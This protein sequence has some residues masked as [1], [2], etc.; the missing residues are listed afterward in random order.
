ME[1]GS[2]QTNSKPIFYS[3]YWY[4]ETY[5][6]TP[7]IA[8][9]HQNKLNREKC[10][11]IRQFNSTSANTILFYIIYDITIT[12]YQLFIG[13]LIYYTWI[14]VLCVTCLNIP[15]RKTTYLIHFKVNLIHLNLFC[16]SSSYLLH[17]INFLLPKYQIF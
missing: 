14:S 16:F 7:Y 2:Y 6:Q 1:Q 4:V 17:F 15:V 8:W 9:F 3:W 12:V 10:I 5:F 13:Y 11:K